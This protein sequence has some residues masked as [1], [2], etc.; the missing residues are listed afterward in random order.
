MKIHSGDNTPFKNEI[1]NLWAFAF[2]DPESF[3]DYYFDEV[4]QGENAV[5]IAD[6]EALAA[7]LELVPYT[8]SVRGRFLPASYIVGVSVAGDFRGR[9]LSTILMKAGLEK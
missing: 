1:K 6:G 3:V 9:G 8:L 5:S 2:S 4:W 7:A